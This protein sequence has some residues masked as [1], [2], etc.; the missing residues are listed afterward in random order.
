MKSLVEKFQSKE[1]VQ[2]AVTDVVGKS[3]MLMVG[4]MI[5]YFL[6]NWLL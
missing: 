3:M 1:F 5:G 6:K 2:N 4:L